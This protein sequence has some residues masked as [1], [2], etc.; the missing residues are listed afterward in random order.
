MIS[1]VYRTR[2]GNLQIRTS[3]APRAST[4]LEEN[5]FALVEGL[6]TSGEV[7]ELREELT[8]L[9]ESTRPDVRMADK[10]EEDYADFRYEALLGDREPPLDYRL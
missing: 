5:G 6:F 9:F 8:D 4:E 3:A 1:R 2:G 7:D 10:T